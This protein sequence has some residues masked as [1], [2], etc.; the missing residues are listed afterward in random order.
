MRVILILV[1]FSLYVLFEHEPQ[2]DDASTSF[3]GQPV[4]TTFQMTKIA[5]FFFISRW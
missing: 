5:M 3:K 2:Q 1:I 4:A